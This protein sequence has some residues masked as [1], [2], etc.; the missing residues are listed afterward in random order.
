MLKDRSYEYLMAGIEGRVKINGSHE[1]APFRGNSSAYWR[2]RCKVY[3]GHHKA[4][5]LLLS[6]KCYD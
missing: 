1:Q 3:S 6:E 2:L 4:F 5:L